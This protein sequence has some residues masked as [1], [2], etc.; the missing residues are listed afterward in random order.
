[1]AKQ[2]RMMM[3]AALLMM[4]GAMAFGGETMAM[5]TVAHVDLQRY[6]GRWYEVARLPL[7]WE[8]KCASDV[9]ATYTLL[10]DG[11]VD[12]LNQ[13]RKADGTMTQSHGSATVVSKDGAGAED[14]SNSRLKVTFFWPF[15]GDY[16]ILA[17]DPEYRWAMV[18]TPNRENLWVLSRTKVLDKDVMAKLLAK[19]RELGFDTGKLIY[20]VQ[21]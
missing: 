20:T 21:K 15:R 14:K 2:F 5:P 8:K 13:C 6:A 17:L 7:Y 11:K 9:T 1:M 18:G 10:P 4:A 3:S 19:A 16:W 12:V